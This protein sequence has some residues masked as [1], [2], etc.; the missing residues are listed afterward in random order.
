MVLDR[1]WEKFTGGAILPNR[2]R[3]HIT[4]NKRGLIYFN[5]NC[6]RMLGRPEAVHLFFNRSKDTIALRPASERLNDV[7]PV[8][9]RS[10]AYFVHASP[11]C[12]HFGIKLTTTE[13]F[14]GPDVDKEGHLHLD[15]SSTVT[16]SGSGRK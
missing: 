16:V 3:I 6:H 8:R 12:K 5:A 14:V 10:G 15:L 11:F 1:G 7:F 4:I 9:E 13:R 2:D